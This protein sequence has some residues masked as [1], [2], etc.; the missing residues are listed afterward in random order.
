VQ[1]GRDR[2]AGVAGVDA[3]DRIAGRDPV[4]GRDDRADRF[5]RGA[6]PAGVRDA[7]H[8]ATGH[9]AGVDDDPGAG[10]PHRRPGRG[11]EVDAAVTGQPGL[12]RRIERPDHPRLGNRPPE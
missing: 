5:V 12:G 8:A 11:G 1:A 9:R 7:D 10:G 4:T 2:A 6:Q 3:P